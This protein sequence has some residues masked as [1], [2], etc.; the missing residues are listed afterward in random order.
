MNFAR[1]TCALGH[2][3][4][5][6]SKRPLPT[7]SGFFFVLANKQEY[8]CTIADLDRDLTAIEAKAIRDA[9]VLYTIVGG[10]VVYSFRALDN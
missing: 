4:A 2:R 10:R 3:Q 6:Y 5:L 9:R 8:R 1:I 7:G